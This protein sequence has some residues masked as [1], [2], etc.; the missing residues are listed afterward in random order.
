MVINKSLLS[1]DF[2]LKCF[3]ESLQGSVVCHIT[4]SS[5][6]FGIGFNDLI[7]S[8]QEIPLS[9]HFAPCSDSKHTSFCADAS[10]LGTF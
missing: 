7:Y 10:N 5:T 6:E 1:L 8:F 4:G 2:Q 9:S 3:H